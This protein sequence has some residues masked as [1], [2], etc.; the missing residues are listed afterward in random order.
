MEDLLFLAIIFPFSSAFFQTIF[1]QLFPLLYLDSLGPILAFCAIVFARYRFMKPWYAS[2]NDPFLTKEGEKV[3]FGPK[4]VFL[5]R[6]NGVVGVA[7]STQYV[8][9]LYY[10]II[11][12]GDTT[13]SLP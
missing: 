9:L 5:G 7:F 8:L 1:P 6:K 3:I 11:I 13:P 2:Q 4:V 12:D 10:I